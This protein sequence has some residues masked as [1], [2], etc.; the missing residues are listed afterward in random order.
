MHSADATVGAG[1]AKRLG[2]IHQMIDPTQAERHAWKLNDEPLFA[3]MRF[4]STVVDPQRFRDAL[5]V[6]AN[7]VRE[8]LW[9]READKL[10]DSMQHSAEN[11]QRRGH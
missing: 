4:D 3:V 8:R 2:L 5:T 11:K 7:E 9:E 1:V 6:Q 10:A